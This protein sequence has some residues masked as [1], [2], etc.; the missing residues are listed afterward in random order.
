MH[1]ASEQ[2]GKQLR[3]GAVIMSIRFK[4]QWL[5]WLDDWVDVA[6]FGDRKSAVAFKKAT[7][8]AWPSHSI[9]VVWFTRR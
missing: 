2:G 8:I 5:L 4:V 7:Q 3:L 9:R 6:F 1:H